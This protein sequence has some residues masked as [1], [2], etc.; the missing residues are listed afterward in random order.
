MEYID[1]KIDNKIYADTSCTYSNK[2]SSLV[3]NEEMQQLK[4]EI[5]ML[6]NDLYTC[7]NDL[8]RL[9]EIVSEFQYIYQQNTHQTELEINT[10]YNNL[11]NHT[12]SF[13]AMLIIGNK[14]G[15][16]GESNIP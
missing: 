4:N 3:E 16:K 2:N 10:L 9:K 7:R 12:N 13:H 8:E 5:A 6:N 11:S 14:D 1:N 15:E